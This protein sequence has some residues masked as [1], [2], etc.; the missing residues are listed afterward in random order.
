M[1]TF[2]SVGNHRE[3]MVKEFIFICKGTQ[4]KYGNKT[5]KIFGRVAPGT[6]TEKARIS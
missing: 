3:T 6:P 4:Q 2:C 5:I 1:T